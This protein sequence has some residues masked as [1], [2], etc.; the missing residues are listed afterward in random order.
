MLVNLQ[1]FKYKYHIFWNLI[2][3]RHQVSICLYTFNP[4]L[5][6]I[7]FDLSYTRSL[8][9]R[10]TQIKNQEELPSTACKVVHARS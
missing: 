10:N 6:S 4:S 8:T 1:S 9:H 2:L 3:V 5:L 7:E